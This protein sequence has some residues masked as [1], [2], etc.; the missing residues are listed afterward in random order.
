[1][2]AAAAII[3]AFGSIISGIG[4]MQ[5]ANYQAQIAQMNAEIARDNAKR[6]IDKAQLDQED[7]DKKS[8]VMQG[9]IEAAQ[10]VSGIALTSR[11][12]KL[13]RKT[14]LELGRKDALNVRQ[15]GEMEAYNHKV[16]A[17]NQTA[18]AGLYRMQ[19]TNS[20]LSGFV[21]GF[22]SLIGNSKSTAF[23]FA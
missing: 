23:K 16:A 14:A 3:G 18:Q 2:T 10:S 11:T 7:Q 8:I 21:N 19:G 20:L 4:Q 13:T 5:A 15:A 12:S 6:A 1:M 17:A 22:S 9:E